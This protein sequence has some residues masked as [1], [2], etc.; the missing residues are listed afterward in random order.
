ML[1]HGTATIHMLETRPTCRCNQRHMETSYSMYVQ[2]SNF[3]LVQAWAYKLYGVSKHESHSFSNKLRNYIMNVHM[4]HTYADILQT[5]QY[6]TLT[7]EQQQT[8]T[9]GRTVV[10]CVA[11]SKQR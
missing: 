5:L 8:N 2:S 6:N 10:L 11:R 9:D 3:M 4:V 7:S 1:E